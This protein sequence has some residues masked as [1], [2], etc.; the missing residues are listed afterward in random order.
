MSL[1]VFVGVVTDAGRLV[2][3]APK[4][5][6][7]YVARFIGEEVEVEVRKRRSKRSTEQNAYYWSV[8][9]P[10]LAEHCGYSH[11][12]MHEALKA[13]FLGQ[14]DMSRGLLRIGSTTKLSTTEFADYVERITVWAAGELGVVISAPERVVVKR[15]KAA[16]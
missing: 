7:A 1:N 11:D 6:K 14:E 3:D 4:V 13:K 5:F 16:A 12:E 8:I 15:K 10:P 2:L 9:I